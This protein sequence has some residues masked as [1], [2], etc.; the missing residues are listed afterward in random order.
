M[1]M[2]LTAAMIGALVFAATAIT[3]ALGGPSLHQMIGDEVA[4][5]A[6]KKKKR[7]PR[8]PT[9]PAGP[10]GPQGEP[11]TAR[12]Y[13]LISATPA[14]TAAAVFRSK[15]ITGPVAHPSTGLYCVSAPGLSPGTTPAVVS[16]E[17]AGTS[18]PEGNATAQY[19]IGAAGCAAGTFPV[20]TY[21]LPSTAPVTATESDTVA[22][23]IMIP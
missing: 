7:G 14:P 5:L 16:A 15:G 3:P 18:S 6:K 17:A 12:A 19:F 10:Q 8:G 9:G 22:F 20:A 21:R 23:T 1:S 4:K 11:G 13:A 2:R